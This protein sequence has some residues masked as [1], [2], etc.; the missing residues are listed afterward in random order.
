M[1]CN[2][3]GYSIA[4]GESFCK[5][6][7]SPVNMEDKVILIAEGRMQSDQNQPY[8]RQLQY[9]TIIEEEVEE[10]K[11]DKKYNVIRIGIVAILALILCFN[12]ILIF[13]G[14]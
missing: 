14:I 12:L 4:K 11:S 2:K 9:G 8:L 5:R 1:Y 13:L 3:C 7:G 10:D 6:C